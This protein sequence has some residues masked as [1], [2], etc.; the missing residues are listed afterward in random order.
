MKVDF[1]RK[2]ALAVD[3]PFKERR[4]YPRFILRIAL[5]LKGKKGDSVEFNETTATT[6][7]GAGGFSCNCLTHLVEG[8]LVDVFLL[9]KGELSLGTAKVVRVEA[10]S[11]PWLTYS[12]VFDKPIHSWF[13]VRE[14]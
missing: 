12:F 8:A 2:S 11:P 14:G 3:K 1:K 6:A 5:R 9:A 7:V 10:T 4:K 13:L